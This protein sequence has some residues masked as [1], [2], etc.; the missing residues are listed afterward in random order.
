M[1]LRATVRRRTFPHSA[2]LPYAARGRREHSM[3]VIAIIAQG[4]MG[5]GI[6][7]RLARHGATVLTSLAGR[8]AAS[9][10]RAAEAGMR[11]ATPAELAGALHAAFFVALLLVAVAFV[12]TLFVPHTELRHTMGD[13]RSASPEIVEEAA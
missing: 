11:D 5:A 8:S 3:A 12:A 6:G 1:P 2:A 9:A 4:A 13:A 7:R 10:K